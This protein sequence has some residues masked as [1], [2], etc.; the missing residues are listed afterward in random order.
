M[1]AIPNKPN[2]SDVTELTKGIA[3]AAKDATYLAVGLGVLGLQKAWI[4]RDAIQQWLAD[5]EW[6]TGDGTLDDRLRE[7]RV[8][9]ARHA[10]QLDEV[11]ERAV[12]QVESSLAPFEAQL[13]EPARAMAQRAR[14]Q[15]NDARTRLTER[16][17][18]K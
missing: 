3:G 6:L 11:L 9:V 13:P 1:T 10:G 12:Q 8:E 18:S 5:Q 16:L 17:A 15:A 2:F 7:L 4:H 14:T